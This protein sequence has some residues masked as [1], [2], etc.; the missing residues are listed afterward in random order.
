MPRL[1]IL[2]AGLVWI[3]VERPE[4]DY[5]PYLGPDWKPEYEG[6]STLVWNHACW[7]DILVGMWWGL[8]SFLSKMGVRSYPGVGIIAENIQS[9]FLK[10][11][12]TNKEKE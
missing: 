3:N 7:M 11:T 2:V 10:R 1:L 6:A 5:R 9:V 8:P 4:I 12:G